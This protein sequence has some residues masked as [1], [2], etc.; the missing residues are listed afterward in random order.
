M[1]RSPRF[2]ERLSGRAIREVEQRAVAWVEAETNAPVLEPERVRRRRLDVGRRRARTGAGSGHG[3]QGGCHE[4]RGES[5]HAVVTSY[6]ARPRLQPRARHLPEP[7]PDVA[8]ADST[9]RVTT[10]RTPHRGLGGGIG[11]AR[12]GSA[13]PV[14]AG[15]GVHGQARR[16]RG[17]LAGRAPDGRWLA[18]VSNR[19][20][21]PNVWRVGLD[22]APAE[23]LTDVVGELG[24][25]RWSPDGRRL[26]YVVTDPPAEQELRQAREKRDAR[27][28][29][30]TYRFARLYSLDLW[31]GAGRAGRPL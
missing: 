20:G 23:Q 29:G 11:A 14:D 12:A 7:S 9:A 25:F 10:A 3:R 30:E 1:P 26:A 5:L 2:E 28:V 21:K 6:A 4:Q 13:R 8:H 22:A 18:F 16:R 15:A 17:D 27:V 24:E 31:A 19:S